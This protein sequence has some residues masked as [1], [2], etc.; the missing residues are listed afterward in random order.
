METK[1]SKFKEILEKVSTPETMLQEERKAL[2]S[3]LIEYVNNITPSRLFRYRPCNEM[4]FDAFYNDKI[5]AV[6]A[7]MFN[8][9][10]DCLTQYDKNYLY[11][12]IKHGSSIEAIKQL[13]DH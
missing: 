9:P 1:R 5:Y 2:L 4:Q 11:N 12:S 10:Y 7:Q 3:P 8:D 13:R 6:N